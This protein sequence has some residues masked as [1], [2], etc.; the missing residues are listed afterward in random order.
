MCNFFLKK[1]Q[2]TAAYCT[3]DDGSTDNNPA[4]KI[5]D[6][7]NA[8]SDLKC[9]CWAATYTC[10]TGPESTCPPLEPHNSTKNQIYC[11]DSLDDQINAHTNDVAIAALILGLVEI[12]GL[13]AL[14]CMCCSLRNA[15]EDHD[16]QA[17]ISDSRRNRSDYK[18]AA[19]P[20]S[21][22]TPSAN[23]YASNSDRFPQPTPVRGQGDWA[24]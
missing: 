23:K 19:V 8:H 1:K 14:V 20:Q 16:T 18:Y 10:G 15:K 12:L 2:Y 24:L 13:L 3:T 22:Y 9:N 21:A 11:L 6:A 17:L 5:F 7:I 4:Q